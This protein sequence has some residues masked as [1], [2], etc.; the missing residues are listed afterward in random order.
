MSSKRPY[1]SISHRYENPAARLSF[2]MRAAALGPATLAQRLGLPG[3]E[4]FYRIAQS[5]E[6]MPPEIAR[7]I[8]RHYPQIDFGWLLTGRVGGEAE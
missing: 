1:F 2:V 3:P 6:P 5:R 7:L 8:H 4:A